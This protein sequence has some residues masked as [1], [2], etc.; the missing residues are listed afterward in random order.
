MLTSQ[1]ERM[2]GINMDTLTLKNS[3]YP[4]QTYPYGAA[5][6]LLDTQYTIATTSYGN[7][8]ITNI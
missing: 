7:T 1:M 6:E 5:G 3:Y 8:I 4:I 2:D